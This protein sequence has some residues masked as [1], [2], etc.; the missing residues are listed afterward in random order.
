[1]SEQRKA[2]RAYRSEVRREGAERT[3]KLILDAAER[4]FLERGFAATTVASIAASAG[5]A[6]E[7][8]YAT[9]GTKARLLETLVRR[10]VRGPSETEVLAQPGPAAVREATNR[11]AALRLFADDISARLQRVAP[12][13]AVL[14]AAA[15]SNLALAK[16]Y[17][18]LH[19]A[20]LRNLA[21][22]AD[23]LAKIEPLRPSKKETTETIWALASPELYQLLTSVQG[24]TRAR[25]AAWLNTTLTTLL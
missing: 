14:A 22:L 20:R 21:A 19:T 4:C 17:Q 8:V 25:Y 1:M 16:L 9:F 12:L 11:E 10:A 23:T 24:W 6:A 5:T 18:E 7:T 13:L 15:P 3:R 2:R